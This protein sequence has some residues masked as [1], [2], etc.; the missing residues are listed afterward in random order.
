MLTDVLIAASNGN[1]PRGS[2]FVSLLPN[3]NIYSPSPLWSIHYVAG[4]LS[5]LFQRCIDISFR[6]TF[7]ADFVLPRLSVAAAMD[8][9]LISSTLMYGSRNQTF[10]LIHQESA[11]EPVGPPSV[12]NITTLWKIV[13]V[14][15]HCWIV[16]SLMYSRSR[17]DVYCLK[18]CVY[19]TYTLLWPAS[20]PGSYSGC[21]QMYRSYFGFQSLNIWF[22]ETVWDD[23]DLIW[24]CTFASC[25]TLLLHFHFSFRLLCGLSMFLIYF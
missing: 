16:L 11:N 9:V 19:M 20:F 18:N 23:K 12:N 7:R 2:S 25:R 3:R 13:P 1:G 17:F 15:E 22:E 6:Q 24:Y 10:I 21:T 5:S 14:L 8:L 4:N